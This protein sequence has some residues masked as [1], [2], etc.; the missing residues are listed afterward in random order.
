[1]DAELAIVIDVARSIRADPTNAATHL[2]DAGM[3]AEEFT[4]KLWGIAE[5]PEQSA[6][7]SAGVAE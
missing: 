7:Y 6:I 3:T 4:A 2:A 1:V 5:D